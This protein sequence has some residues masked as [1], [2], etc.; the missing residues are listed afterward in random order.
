[1]IIVLPGESPRRLAFHPAKGKGDWHAGMRRAT[2]PE[3]MSGNGR[4]FCPDTESQ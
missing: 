1:M 4:C 2:I 3:R